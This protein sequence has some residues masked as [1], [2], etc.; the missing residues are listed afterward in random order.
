MYNQDIY[1]IPH[2]YK[3]N[4][5][6]LGIIE[7]QSLYAALIWFIPLTYLNF[8]LMPFGLNTKV[9]VFIIFILPPTLLILVGVGNDTLP[10]YL[11]YIYNFYKNA[12]IYKYGR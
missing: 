12:R 9:F 4:G 3:D 10:N 7:L 8:W 1:I 6:I 11:K 2:N 5:K